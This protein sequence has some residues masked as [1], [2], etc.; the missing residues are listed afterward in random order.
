M[1]VVVLYG[2][3]KRKT[4]IAQILI[5]CAASR[6]APRQRDRFLIH[7]IDV[8]LFPHVLIASNDHR[9]VV[10]PEKERLFANVSI[11]K[12]PVKRACQ[13]DNRQHKRAKGDCQAA[14]PL[15]GR[16]IQYWIVG[17]AQDNTQAIRRWRLRAGKRQFAN[18]P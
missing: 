14:S 15:F 3:Q 16:Q 1:L 17:F 7:S 6:A 4:G 9:L 2:R 12:K 8:H 13:H 11:A 10:A 18:P 5:N